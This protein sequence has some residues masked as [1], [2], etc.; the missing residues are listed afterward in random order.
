MEI[1]KLIDKLDEKYPFSLQESWDNS[2]LQV[3]NPNNEVK[4][5]LISLDLEDEGVDMA[6]ENNCNLIINHHPYLFSPSKSIDLSK[7]FYKRLEKLIKNDITV[8]AFH[9]NLDIAYDGLNDNLANILNIKASK[10][11][12]ANKDPGLGRY[13]YIEKCEAREYIKF[14]KDTLKAKGLIVYGDLDKKISK[15]AVC[16]G[17]GGELIDDA[18]NKSCNLIITGDVKYHDGMDKANEGII[19]VDAGHFASENHVIYK[20]KE[21]IDKLVESKVYTYSKG[22]SFRKIF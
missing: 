12:E 1:R 5:I 10:V 19:I 2:G 3:G 13:G 17:S 7:N 4:N 21:E 20:L 15:I 22:D 18:I 14:I 16:G 8:Y 6:I 9:T 11:L